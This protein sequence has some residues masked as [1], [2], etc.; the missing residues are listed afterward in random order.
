[1]VI[2][3]F[4]MHGLMHA[5]N[6]VLIHRVWKPC[7][8]AN[9]S[10][11][12]SEFSE[13]LPL[14]HMSPNSTPKPC[15]RLPLEKNQCQ[16]KTFSEPEQI[17]SGGWQRKLATHPRGRQCP[18]HLSKQPWPANNFEQLGTRVFGKTSVCSSSKKE[19]YQA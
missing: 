3:K 10:S 12:A 5:S 2:P 7:W 9:P 18:S 1:M 8:P 6:S 13:K 4:F 19:P 15:V 11:V 14:F 16:N 17:E